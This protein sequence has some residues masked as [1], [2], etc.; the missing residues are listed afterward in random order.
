MVMRLIMGMTLEA[1]H[2]RL[3][4]LKKKC[5]CLHVQVWKT[6]ASMHLYVFPSG[7]SAAHPSFNVE[8]FQPSAFKS[9][10]LYTPHQMLRIILLPVLLITV[11]C[12]WSH[13]T[14]PFVFCSHSAVLSMSQ[15]ASM[16]AALPTGSWFMNPILVCHYCLQKG[17][18]ML[19]LSLWES[20]HVHK[21]NE[22]S[23]D[24]LWPAASQI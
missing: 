4:A 2:T 1:K 14:C 8:I 6:V 16:S 17:A 20:P 21:H 11:F 5:V 23:S 24:N 22:Y 18:L 19:N 9:P 10:E 3:P 13:W 7:S 15:H 12:L